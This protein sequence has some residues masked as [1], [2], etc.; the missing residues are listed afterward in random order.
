[1]VKNVNSALSSG[2]ADLLMKSLQNGA[3]DLGPVHTSAGQLY[4]EE[5]ASMRE[6][7]G[8]D[9]EFSDIVAALKGNSLALN[10]SWHQT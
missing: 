7:K 1:M 8:D 9:L 6:E 10:Y 2:D 3:V 4:M 5:L